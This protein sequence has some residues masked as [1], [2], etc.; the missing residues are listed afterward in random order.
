MK[1]ALEEPMILSK[2]EGG[3]NIRN[4]LAG[5]SRSGGLCHGQFHDSSHITDKRV[6]AKKFARE[7]LPNAFCIELP[8]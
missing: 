7:S 4:Q 8:W 5:R 3:S 2:G 1:E 6:A